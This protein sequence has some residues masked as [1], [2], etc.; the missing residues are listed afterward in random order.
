MNVVR[1]S[2]DFKHLVG[3]VHFFDWSGVWESGTE[4][5]FPADSA[6]VLTPLQMETGQDCPSNVGSNSCPC[7]LLR[8]MAIVTVQSM[9]AIVH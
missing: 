3:E 2:Q 5:S 6:L 7:C 4:T 9:F 8:I 1:Q